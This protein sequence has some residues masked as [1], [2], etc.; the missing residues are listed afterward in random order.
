MVNSGSLFRMKS[1]EM[2]NFMQMSVAD[3]LHLVNQGEDFIK[4]LYKWHNTHHQRHK[5]INCQ[6]QE[7]TRM[8]GNH[9]SVGFRL[10]N[11][12]CLTFSNSSVVHIMAGYKA[13]ILYHLTTSCFLILTSC[14]EP[15][16]DL[17]AAHS[18]FQLSYRV[19]I[20]VHCGLCLSREQIS[21]INRLIVK[22]IHE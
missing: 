14:A 8:L 15:K 16:S 19:C 13:L 2:F 10:F 9:I 3:M 5:S 17:I 6:L 12:A 21:V 20:W 7:E 1:S 18:F 11:G 4:T 22:N